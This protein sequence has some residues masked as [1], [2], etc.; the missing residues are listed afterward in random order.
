MSG[1][2]G[3]AVLAALRKM[4]GFELTPVIAVTASSLVSE[5]ANLKK[6]FSGYLRKPF[7]QQ[8]LFDELAHFLPPQAETPTENAEGSSGA[9]AGVDAPPTGVG[10]ELAAEL[11]RLK[12]ETWPAIR[13]RVAVNESKAFGRQ[14]EELG[15]RW[16][17]P[18]LITYS[19]LLIRHAE[20]YAVV[21]LEKHLVEFG[22][23][24]DGLDQ[25]VTV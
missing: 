6:Q 13:D 8:D 16:N 18:A 3:F 17:C 20:E 15:R 7:S 19:E 4:P 12:T 9:Q 22:N 25:S 24:V 23:L 11:R 14:L 10:P 2:D 1:M 5:E 21:E